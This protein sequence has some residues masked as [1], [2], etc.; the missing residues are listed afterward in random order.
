MKLPSIEEV[1]EYAAHI[2]LTQDDA[3]EFYDYFEEVG[4]VVGRTRKPMKSWEAGLRNWKRNKNK[5]LREKHGTPKV[6]PR[7]KT[8][9]KT[10]GE[11]PMPDWFRNQLNDLTT[12]IQSPVKTLWN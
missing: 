10:T 12:K 1:T 9:E 2:G 11:E 6:S 4:W 3:E 8:V 5:W 7:G